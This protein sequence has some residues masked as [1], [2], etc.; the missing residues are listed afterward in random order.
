MQ[1]RDFFLHL[2]HHT[3]DKAKK[4]LPDSVGNIYYLNLHSESVLG[5]ISLFSLESVFNN[6]LLIHHPYGKDIIPQMPNLI[7]GYADMHMNAFYFRFIMET[8]LVLRSIYGALTNE[9]YIGDANFSIVIAKLFTQ[10]KIVET[11]EATQL[12][13]LL[14]QIRNTIHGAG[15]QLKKS[16]TLEYGGKQFHF[17]YL[18]SPEFNI[19]APIKTRYDMM[20]HVFYFI[21]TLLL[22]HKDKLASRHPIAVIDP[23]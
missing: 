17:N 5:D 4:Y 16:K 21:D 23:T 6:N 9:K 18:E 7:K 11:N 15:I 22:E 3:G 8:E 20:M 13:S 12:F 1:I 10:G 19:G 2:N 14:W